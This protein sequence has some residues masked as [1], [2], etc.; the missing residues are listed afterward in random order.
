MLAMFCAE[1]V[2]SMRRY[3]NIVER[4]LGPFDLEFQF[5]IVL[6]QLFV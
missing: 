6:E 3:F 1:K 5:W 2:W 4:A